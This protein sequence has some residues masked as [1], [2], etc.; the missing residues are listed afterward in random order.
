[1]SIQSNRAAIAVQLAAALAAIEVDVHEHAGRFDKNELG[2]IAAKAPAVFLAMLNVT[3]MRKEMGEVAGVVRWGVFVITKDTSTKS[4]DDIGLEVVQVLTDLITDYD[5]GLEAQPAERFNINNLYRG[6]IAKKGVAM[7][8]GEWTQLMN[9]G[10]PFD[11]NTL[12]DWL[13]WNAEHSLAPGEDE[14]AA[15]DKVTAP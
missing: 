2:R 8:A 5:F 13:V 4:R 1:M 9:I 14:P 12:N 10:T 15:I 3:D 11:I 6:G 7:W